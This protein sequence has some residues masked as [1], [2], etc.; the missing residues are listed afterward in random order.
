MAQ[1]CD[2]VV[3]HLRR[4]GEPIDLMYLGRR[5]RR[6]ETQTVVGGH[7]LRCPLDDDPPHAMR[8][9]W[10]ALP[11]RDYSHVVAFGG[12]LP[13]HAAP[14]YAAWLGAPLIT[15]LR[16]ND[17][18]TGV[19]TPRRRAALLEALRQS[20]AIATVGRSIAARVRPLAPGVPVEVIANG[21]DLAD[22][23]AFGGDRARAAARRAE[24][25]VGDRAVIGLFG[26]LKRKKGL[27][28]LLDAIVHGGMAERCHLVCVG[29]LEPAMERLL[30]A[31][32]E[33][34]ITRAPFIDRFRLLE[35]Y[36][37]CDWVALP[38]LYDGL[39]NVA[40][41]AMLLGIPLICTTAGGLADVV[42]DGAQGFTCAPA[43]VDELAYALRRALDCPPERRSQMG[44]RA[45]ALVRTRFTAHHE[46]Q[47]YQRLFDRVGA[48][49]PP[50]SAT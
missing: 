4:A 7:D 47:A 13:L 33:L 40:L 9:A 18:D 37:A 32:P 29:R 24:W 21:I 39:P 45:A 20:A 41:E 12:P 19:F 49:A 30:D 3:T 43:D 15:L 38:S 5:L 2:R 10:S 42:E 25:G 22:W 34:S 26:H 44:T 8:R 50:G 35:W 14:V 27:D 28:L 11:R 6:W 46:R 31:H 17:L 16:G 48:G 1:A 23:A 36:P